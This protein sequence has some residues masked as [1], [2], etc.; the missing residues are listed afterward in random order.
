MEETGELV[1]LLKNRER[2]EKEMQEL[3]KKQ[4]WIEKKLKEVSD[5]ILDTCDHKWERE[6]VWVGPYDKPDLICS[7]CNSIR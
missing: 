5:K 4:K 1:S 7:I 2:L 6:N 3:F